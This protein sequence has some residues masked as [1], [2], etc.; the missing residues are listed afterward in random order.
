MVAENL[1]NKA[2]PFHSRNCFLQRTGNGFNAHSFCFLSVNSKMFSSIGSG[3]ATFSQYH[4]DQQR[5]HNGKSQ[6][7][8]ART[9]WANE[10]H[11][12]FLPFVLRWRGIRI[13]HFGLFVPINIDGSFIPR[14]KTFY[15]EFTVGLVTAII[16][17]MFLS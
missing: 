16:S 4:Q 5:K 7:G 6:I 1:S 13:K 3:I 8:I 11:I 15:T 9:I 2:S 14:N 12:E 10:V 17:D